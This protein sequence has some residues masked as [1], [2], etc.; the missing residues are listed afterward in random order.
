MKNKKIA[1]SLTII[2]AVILFAVIIT[3][4][5][6]SRGINNIKFDNDKYISKG[7]FF[8]KIVKEYS[9]SS[10]KYSYD[11]IANTKN[12][13][14]FSDILVEWEYITKEQAKNPSNPLTRE[15]AAYI[16]VNSVFEHDT[17]KIEINDINDC[18]NKQTIIDSVGMGIFELD[19]GKFNPKSYV[20][21]EDAKT[22]IENANNYVASFNHSSSNEKK[23]NDLK[24]TL[25]NKEYTYPFGKVSDFVNKGW[26]VKDGKEILNKTI[27]DISS[28]S[29]ENMIYVGFNSISLQQDN[30]V[31][32]ITFDT[33][34]TKN[35]VIDSEIVYLKVYQL[36]ENKTSNID[37]YGFNFNTEIDEKDLKELFGSK[38]YS[39]TSDS[40]EEKYDKGLTLNETYNVLLELS[41]DIKTDK[42]LSIGISK[43]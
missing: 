24:I 6:K 27:E 14:V 39:I 28:S 26:E 29:D 10:G 23:F 38:N 33:S 1:I 36:D 30:I 15:L 8:E 4:A 11:E 25:N 19:D 34:S 31:L 2:L 41:K 3:L 12:Y 13:T 5:L 40:N 21:H 22:I 42:L 16:L 37:F 7:Q 20:K 9:M 35:K 17:Y 43:N 18:K 32:D